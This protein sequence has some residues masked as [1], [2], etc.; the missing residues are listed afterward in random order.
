MIELI[1]DKRFKSV[2]SFLVI[3]RFVM[4][5]FV[6]P[7]LLYL[8]K[9]LLN[10][11]QVQFMSTEKMFFLLSKPS[12]WIYLIL[13]LGMILFLL[14]LELSS[15]IVLSHYDNVENSLFPFSLT[16]LKWTLKPKNLVF[17]PVL[18]TVI[19]GFHFGMTSM[20]TDSLFI[21]EFILDTIIKTPS[22][23][24]LY[25]I[26]S[27]IAF[28][29][30]FHLLFLFHHLF[31]GKNNFKEAINASVSMVHGNRINFLLSAVKIWIHV[32]LASTIIYLGLISVI[33][34]IIYVL[35]PIFSF[36][37]ISLSVLF[38]INKT[39]VFLGIS[40][41]AAVNVLFI[42]GKYQEYGGTAAQPKEVVSIRKSTTPKYILF[43]L[44]VVTLIFQGYGA[45]RTTMSF[46]SP[47]YLEHTVYITSHRGNSSI[48]PENTIAAIRAAKDELADAAEIDVQLTADGYVVVI[49]DFTLSRLAKDSRRVV[50][51]TLEEIKELEVGSW[52]SKEFTGEKM[53]TLE[54]VFEEA[55]TSIKL[56][57]ELKPTNDEDELAKAV[58]DII[59]QYNYEERVVISSLNKQALKKVKKTKPNLDVGYIVPV[60]LGSFE[61]EESIDFYS[62]EMS[63]LT[64]NL[65]EQIK[66]Q[67]K[68]V[69]AWTVNSE[70]DMKRMQ[71]LQVNNIIT[72]D[73]ILAQ[74]VLATS[75]FEKG[76][77]E[78]LS[79][80][81]L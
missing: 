6:T 20:I 44:M 64:K 59:D 34:L 81:E 49:H 38:V 32:T 19:L 13:S 65:V 11:H 57:I 23:L 63:F 67:G 12:V 14:M 16:K 45:Y 53:P 5:L 25:T 54:E 2:L 56:N 78:I 40:S 61:F 42:T 74:K 30:A 18:M 58:I 1:K 15:A 27:I 52:F 29:I 48:A 76:V 9:L 75:L 46:D 10:Y 69:H 8:G 41:F 68:E 33:A 26:I 3:Y 70:E 35:P 43:S 47:E 77:L 79:L 72:D 24:F 50:D 4:Q 39:V 80:L 28:V 60:A 62:L 66:N 22:Y 55:G 31:I 7:S 37:A 21:P 71:R 36:N 17:L 73:P 51:L